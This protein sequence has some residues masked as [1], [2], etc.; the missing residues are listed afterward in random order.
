MHSDLSKEIGKLSIPE[1]I[2]LVEDIWDSIA[3]ESG[4]FDLSLAQKNELEKR[5]LSYDQ[6]PQQIR[7]WEDIK[8]EYIGKK[9]SK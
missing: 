6:N 3:R 8:S 1:R 4:G 9:Q 5:S 2:L 7:S